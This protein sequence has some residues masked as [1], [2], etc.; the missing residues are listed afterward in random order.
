[1]WGRLDFDT[2][3]FR[4]IEVDRLINEGSRVVNLF[5][6]F[7]QGRVDLGNTVQN[8]IF[9][10]QPSPIVLPMK[11][12]LDGKELQKSTLDSAGQTFPKWLQGRA[13]RNLSSWTPIGTRMFALVPPDGQGGRLL[14]VWGVTTPPLLVNPGDTLTLDDGY[15]DLIV[16][17][18][19]MNLAYKEGGKPTADA[20]RGYQP[21]LKRM[22]ELQRFEGVK[23][24]P[25]F[26]IEVDAGAAA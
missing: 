3:F 8:W 12:Y 18:A 15:A 26:W 13:Q 2:S 5:G 6:G 25:R 10:R 16:D 23:I 22:R 1:M 20:L 4:Q 19:Y 7:S 21:W 9:Y 11:V 24:N 14:Q 17:Y